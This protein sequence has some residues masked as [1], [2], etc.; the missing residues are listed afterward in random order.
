MPN[1]CRNDAPHID[2]FYAGCNKY[3]NGQPLVPIRLSKSCNPLTKAYPLSAGRI[4]ETPS[5]EIR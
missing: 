3:A 5:K 4:H 1:A 2:S